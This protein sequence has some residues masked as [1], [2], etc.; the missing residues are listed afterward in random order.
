MSL[1]QY[2]LKDVSEYWSGKVDTSILNAD[3]YISTENMIVDKGGIVQSSYVPKSGK[4][5]GFSKGDVL[6]SNIRPYF[7]KIWFAEKD[8]GC[9]NDVLVFRA[10]ENIVEP[11]YLYYQL[12]KNDFFDY[13]VAGSN[14]TK[15]PRGNKASIL[16]YKILLPS[17]KSQMAIAS[18]LRAYDDLIKNNIRR[19]KLLEEA[20]I[21]HYKKLKAENSLVESAIDELC[22]VV[23]GQSPESNFY[24]ENC[25]GL[26]FHQGVTNFNSRFVEHKI[27]TTKLT[28]IAEPNDILFSVRAPVG[29]LNISLDKLCIGR[30]LAAFKSKKNH[31]SHLYYQLK[32]YFFQEDMLG[33]GSIFNSV[34]K[35]ELLNVK[36]K[37]LPENVVQEFEN[38]S[39]P[40]DNQIKCLTMQ[41]HKLKE[42]RDILLPRLMNG[43]IEI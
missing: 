14:G 10:K 6:I 37:T 12:S 11:L 1:K 3:N 4:A 26:P 33:S 16:E 9:S 2:C 35:N 22:Y 29:R 13:M 40:I 36:L 19:I 32:D 43:E 42:A 17:L 23:M 28:R 5:S 41:N 24:N 21:I 25:E 15:M 8:G 38:F 27:Y 30:G 34:T 18:T 20:V 31:Q 39:V 7:K